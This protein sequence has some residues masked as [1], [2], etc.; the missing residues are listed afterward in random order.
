MSQSARHATLL[1][2]QVHSATAEL[3]FSTIGWYKSGD[4]GVP[5][6]TRLSYSRSLG[7]KNVFDTYLVQ[8]EVILYL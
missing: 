5:M 6:E 7:G 4:F 1:T 3:R 2:E 8:G